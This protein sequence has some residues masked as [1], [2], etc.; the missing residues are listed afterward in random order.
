MLTRLLVRNFKR[1]REVEIELGSPVVFVGPNDSGKTTALQAIALWDAGLRRWKERREG[2]E[3]PGKRPG[4]TINRRE[5]LAVPVPNAV[6]LWRNLHVREGRRTDGKQQTVNVRVEVLVDGVTDGKAWTCGLEFDFANEESFYCRPLRISDRPDSPRREI[7]PEAYGIQVAY[8]PPMSGLVPNERRIDPGAINVSLGEGRTADVLRNLCHLIAT[9]KEGE[10]RWREV[11]DRIE[12]L[13]GVELDL[14]SYVAE[15]GEIA[16][17]Y[18]TP[19]GVT[20]DLSSA[21]RGLQQTLL[22]LAH[23]SVNPGSVLLLDEPDAHLEILRQRQ[24]YH[25]L[26]EVARDHGSQ[27]VA[28]S[29]SEVLLNEAADRDVVVA[30]VGKPHRID[31]RGSQVLKSLKE[32]GFDQYY[33]AER[34]GW[35]LYLEGSTDLAILR[36]FAD[37]LKHPAREDLAR[38]FVHYVQNQP[39][40]AREH[41]HG[42]QEAK[43]DLV[44]FAL[45]DRLPDFRARDERGLAER[46]WKRREIENYLSQPETLKAYSTESAREMVPGPLFEE[47]ERI[48]RLGVMR[49]CI[50]DLVSPLALRDPSDPW[51][52]NSKASDEFL[53]RLFERFFLELGLPNLMRKTDYHVLARYVPVEKIEPEVLE[54]LDGVRSVAS[55]ARPVREGGEGE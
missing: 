2:K 3:T 31:D 27:I 25:V 23:L 24:I 50:E 28:A 16:M 17:T 49:R 20:L 48:R 51:W 5:L 21:G 30:F 47:P 46:M 18:R 11:C 7:P 9:G 53:D 1:F 13:F 45:F 55:R 22:L 44:G 8:L 14:P 12:G 37:T 10:R 39:S 4:V 36:Q 52:S 6:L 15:R 40:R 43:K 42:L 33:Q 32:I 35:V 54:V 41:F 26:T 38:P 34:T 29:H 19:S